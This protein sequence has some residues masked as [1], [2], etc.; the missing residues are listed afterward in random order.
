MFFH[1]SSLP[2]AIIGHERAVASLLLDI[3]ADNVSHA[4][5]FLGP[6]SIGKYTLA[7][8]FA[9]Q[10]LAD[11]KAP[12]ERAYIRHQMEHLIHPDVLELRQLWIDGIC[13]D[14]EIIARSSN[15]PQMHRKKKSPPAR[16]DTIGI[17][18][19]RAIV[20]Q[21]HQTSISPRRCCLI[22]AAERMNEE[23][24]SAFLKTLEE[25]PSGVCFVLTATHEAHVLPTIL[26]R[27]RVLRLAPVPSDTLSAA[28]P[29]AHDDGA[30]ALRI[31]RGAPGLL[32]RLLADPEELRRHRQLAADAARFW[33]HAS[34]LERQRWLLPF[35]ER[36]QPLDDALLHLHLS[37]KETERPELLLRGAQS[38]ATLQE[39]LETNAHRGLLL[40][41]FC[42]AVEA[43][44]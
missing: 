4:Y 8:W 36:G 5:M 18:D 15:V 42:L 24:A 23:A 33:E 37:L 16:T 25:P 6:A 26:S 21:L 1:M 29:R 41:R 14:W 34:G 28:L 32:L 19:I 39:G 43:A 27:A 35:G 9:W 22:R 10:L 7:R 3:A 40:Q 30:L 31:A 13:D 12:S 44:A 38:L 2:E 17:D 11:Q 20:E